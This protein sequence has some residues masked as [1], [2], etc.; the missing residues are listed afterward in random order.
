MARKAQTN[1]R[2]RL[3]LWLMPLALMAGGAASALGFAPWN[4]WWSPLAALGLWAWLLWRA[5]NWKQAWL[6]GWYFGLGHFLL[7]QHWIAQAFQ[8]QANMPA[9]LGWVAVLLLSMLMAV[10]PALAGLA[11][12]YLRGHPVAR[13]IWLAIFWMIGEWLRGYL[14]SGFA[15]NPL[16]ATQ[17][18][19]LGIAQTAAL[20]GALGLSGLVVLLGASWPLLADQK[21][22]WPV[23]ALW[24]VAAVAAWGGTLVRAPEQGKIQIAIV[25]PNIGQDEKWSPDSEVR[26]V[27][28]Y[29]SLSQQR[30]S[31]GPRLLLW[32]E[33][34][35]QFPLD[36]DPQLRRALVS[37]LQKD[38][39][40]LTGGVKAERNAAGEAI[41]ARNS[42]FVLDQQGR[43]LARYDKNR[44]VPF[45][46]YVPLRRLMEMIGVTRL[47]PGA[48][49]FWP[50][51]G[52]QTIA[53]PHF[54]PVSVRIC[55][56]I[57]YAQDSIARPRRAQWI[58]NSSNDAWFSDV[59]AEMHLAQA[60]LRAIEHRLPVARATPTGISAVIDA[61]GH[62]VAAL[63]RGQAGM[64]ETRLPPPGPVGPY[65][66]WGDGA[67][68]IFLLGLI[69][70]A[71]YVMK[72]Y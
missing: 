70:A 71:I 30:S 54:P 17:L 14:L 43:I 41:G 16:G 69:A 52:P 3:F 40:L 44:L 53:L 31:K 5:P 1:P 11:A 61:R 49:D 57:I 25:Q 72:R 50:G 39:L 42:L 28:R 10:Y 18:E 19:A 55:Y 22:R 66:R 33:A 27:Q 38:D 24:A 20:Y 12:W 4:L 36:E 60:R 48:L 47:V 23:A 35:V 6:C 58:L 59:G 2:T 45:G 56:E 51:P 21:A 37:V 63:G 64:I 9:A 26:N 13:V 67:A 29:L 7:G 62:V 15:W 46:E 65:A 34:A 8:Y 68:F 32:S